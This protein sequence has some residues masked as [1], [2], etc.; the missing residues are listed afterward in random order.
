MEDVNYFA[1]E[2]LKDPD[3]L[4]MI[5]YLDCGELLTGDSKARKL[6]AQVFSF[7]IVDGILYFVDPWKKKGR[8]Q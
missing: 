1:K 7:A 6:V 4:E 3:I 8:K 2:Q 5:R